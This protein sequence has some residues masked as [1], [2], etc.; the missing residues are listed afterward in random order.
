MNIDT[1]YFVENDDNYNLILAADMGDLNVVDLLLNR[2]A[3][4]NAKTEEGATPLMYACQNGFPDVVDT[5]IRKGADVNT[6]PYNGMTALIS[7][8]KTGDYEIASILV[9]AGA[10]VDTTDENG[11][12]ALMYASAYNF[13][14][15]VE[16]CLENGADINQKDWLGNNPLIM[17]AYYGSFESAK[18]LLKKGADVNSSDNAGF[19]PLHIACQQGDYDLAWLLLNK[20]A[21]VNKLNNGR[22]SPMVIAVQKGNQDIIDLLLEYN[23]DINQD[24]GTSRNS[25]D[26][27]RQQK[28]GNMT[29]FLLSKGIKTN[30]YPEIS[31]VHFGMQLDFNGNDF[32]TGPVMGLLDSKYGLDF[33]AGWLFRPAA[34]R[35][36]E[37]EHELYAIQYWEK[38]SVIFLETGKIFASKPV[39][40]GQ[41]GF[42]PC[43][44]IIHSWSSFKGSEAHPD[45]ISKIVPKAGIFWKNDFFEIS[46]S[47]EYLN[48]KIQKISPHRFNMGIEIFINLSKN[49]YYTKEI[50]LF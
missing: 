29:E 24:I 20:G 17:A 25:L 21:N 47:Y 4:V 28:D 44:R 18:L 32:M 50:P 36:L 48:Y 39:E 12:S 2:G 34:I 40:T 43:L 6:A 3:D 42:H 35:I 14:D 10:S 22:I 33:S 19:T 27:A 13:P 45:P 7:V 37:K 38:R 46:F 41:L 23:A 1:S 16:L 9:H 30:R 26:V 11:L 8:S 31:A 49:K 15:I 5:L